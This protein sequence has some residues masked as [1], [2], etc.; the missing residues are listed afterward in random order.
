MQIYI[1]RDG[2][3]FGPYTLEQIQASIGTG[4]IL[5]SDLAWHEGI[6][7]WVPVSSIPGVAQ[8][9]GRNMPGAPRAL[10]RTVPATEGIAL[11]NPLAAVNWSWLFTPIFG[12]YLHMRNWQALGQPREA[13]TA[14]NWFIAS[15]IVALATML[16]W[17]PL[18]G[19]VLMTIWYYVSGRHQIKYVRENFGSDYP[20]CSF[21]RPCFMALF[22]LLT[23]CV[24][25]F[26]LVQLAELMGYN[27]L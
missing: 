26:V 10:R 14:K 3:Q 4:H 15:I 12:T 1:S 19:L 5:P 21:V 18:P 9:P 6:P 13:S 24:V 22:I 7:A 20:R 27:I 16:F 17:G 25:L 2:K 11:W 8:T 23:A